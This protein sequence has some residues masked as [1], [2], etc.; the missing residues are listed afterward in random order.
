MECLS[1]D[2]VLWSTLMSFRE[3]E[4]KTYLLPKVLIIQHLPSFVGDV[5]DWVPREKVYADKWFHSIYIQGI[6]NVILQIE[7]QEVVA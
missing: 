7:F 6:C 3:K 4:G 5:H 1:M 2:I